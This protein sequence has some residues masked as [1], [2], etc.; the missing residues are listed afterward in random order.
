MSLALATFAVAVSLPQLA[1]WHRLEDLT[2]GGGGI[3]LNL[4]TT[5]FGWDISVRHWLYY[6][7]WVTAGILLPR[8]LAARPRHGRAGPGARSG[9]ARSPRRHPA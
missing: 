8:R 6:E 7:A 5:P 2:G 9:T 4:P 3:V 1:K